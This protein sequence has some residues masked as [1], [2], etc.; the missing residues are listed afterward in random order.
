MSPPETSPPASSPPTCTR[1]P[2]PMTP[3]A[4]RV[5]ARVHRC[6]RVLPA[7]VPDRGAARPAVHCGPPVSGDANAAPV[8]N[9]QTNFGGGKTHSMLALW[10]V[11]SGVPSTQFPEDVQDLIGS[12]PLPATVRRV[13]LVGNHLMPTGSTK[14]DGTKVNT[15]WGELAWQL[16]G[17][18]PLPSSP[19]PMRHRRAPGTRCGPC[20]RPTPRASSWW[21]NGWRTPDSC[22]VGRTCRQALSTRSSRSRRRSPRSPRPS[23]AC[24]W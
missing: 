18:G 3:R 12:A 13:A 14:P 10:H 6:R 24:C 9:L 8:V 17:A 22:G 16:G 1:S 23:P 19:T 7:D 20:W 2:S 11:V 5:G 4:P 15:I 21:T